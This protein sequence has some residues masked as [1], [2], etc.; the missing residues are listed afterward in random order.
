MVLSAWLGRPILLLVA[1]GIAL[2]GAT[3][4]DL[5][6]I[7]MMG[8]FFLFFVADGIGSVPWFEI[9]AKTIPARRRGRVMGTG[10]VVGNLLGMGGGVV[11]SWALSEGS[12]LAF[13]LNYAVL[14]ALGG[15]VLLFG[16]VSLSLSIEPEAPPTPK[17]APSVRAVLAQMPGIVAHDRPFALLIM[18]RIL[19]GFVFMAG[20]F[21]ILHA[22]K[23]LGLS[24]DVV[25]TFIAAQ[26]AGSLVAGLLMGL[27]QDRW[28]PL[29]HIRLVLV[30]S[31][32]SPLIALALGPFTAVLGPA[33]LYPYLVLYFML[34]ISMGSMGWPY[35]NW[36]LE[37]ADAA[38][39]PVYIGMINTLSAIVMVAPILGGWVAGF[40]TYVAVFALAMGFAVLGY[41]LSLALPSTRGGKLTTETQRIQR[42]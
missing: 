12:P 31:A 34:G 37:Y 28:G 6:R 5:A 14:Y 33:V 11:V 13:P 35:F 3:R 10:Q 2:T 22:T 4:P 16:A 7:I 15:V 21:Y 24:L 25:G 41:L 39:R 36:I 38:R 18:V 1:L 30:I 40:G 8:G 9:L 26:L 29:V 23:T 32:A 17:D 19:S 27:V 42:K 20:A